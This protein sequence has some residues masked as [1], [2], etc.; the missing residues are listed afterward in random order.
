MMTDGKK[1]SAPLAACACAALLAGPTA[2][3]SIQVTV[4]NVLDAG[5]FSLTPFYLAFHDGSFD[6]F[7]RGDRAS[8]G[9]ERLAEL[10][11]PSGLPPERLA[12]DPG[13]TAQVITQPANG[14]PTIDPG[15][16]GTTVFTLDP[17]GG[18]QRYMTFLSMIV[19]SNDQFIGNGDPLA[20]EI[21]DDAGVFRGP[22]T[23]DITAQFAYD[24]G[25]EVNNP[26]RG[27]AFVIGIDATEGDTEIR[28]AP[29]SLFLRSVITQGEFSL[30]PFVGLN[31]PAGIITQ[32]LDIVDNLAGSSIA[33]ITVE[34]VMPS[35]VPLP[36]AAPLLLGAL[37]SLAFIRRRRIA[38][39]AR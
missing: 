6:A 3:A 39:A 35:P 32:P 21:F 28:Q 36:A 30:D 23:F 20:F 29:S 34:E 1:Y 13:S 22:Q 31:T 12:V 4:E 17:T 24:A 7:N 14:P 18:E 19:P 8:Q 33:R 25:T 15:E 26:T 38:G 10:G 2:A 27:P 11:D 9:V 37:G 16:R 5:G